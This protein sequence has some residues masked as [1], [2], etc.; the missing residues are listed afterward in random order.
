MYTWGDTQGGPAGS[1]SSEAAE[2]RLICF[3]VK[4]PKL[5]SFAVS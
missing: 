5:L 4:S 2:C 3:G 1:G